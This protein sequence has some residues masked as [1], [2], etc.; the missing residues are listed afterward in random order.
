MNMETTPFYAAAAKCG[1]RALWLG[2]VSDS[3]SEDAWE[4]WD[5]LED[6][7]AV[8]AD[9]AAG[10]LASLA[11][12][13]RAAEPLRANLRVRDTLRRLLCCVPGT[14]VRSSDELRCGALVPFTH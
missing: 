11:G 12:R 4:P 3:L 2:H 10:V 8:T 13:W 6:M 1:I 9:W 7:T 14:H 5:D